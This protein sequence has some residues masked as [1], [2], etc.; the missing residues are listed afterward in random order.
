MNLYIRICLHRF[1][2]RKMHQGC[3][4]SP[5]PML[6]SQTLPI[7]SYGIGRH[8]V[9]WPA[10]CPEAAGLQGGGMVQANVGQKVTPINLIVR[11]YMYLKVMLWYFLTYNEWDRITHHTSQTHNKHH[12]HGDGATCP[13]SSKYL[14]NPCCL[15]GGWPCAYIF[16]GLCQRVLLESIN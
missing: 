3:G 8:K 11:Q 12:H 16:Q 6:L 5:L 15:R 9:G 2:Y 10:E 1:V 7:A 13:S 14:M 4:W